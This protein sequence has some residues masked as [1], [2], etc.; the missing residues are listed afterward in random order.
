MILTTS[1]DLGANVFV[2]SLDINFEVDLLLQTSLWGG[3]GHASD[4]GL[5]F[6]YANVNYFY[7]IF[8][9][10]LICRWQEFIMEFFGFDVS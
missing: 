1:S 4:L 3:S 5:L 10:Q 9:S 6:N 7:R 2:F 8:L